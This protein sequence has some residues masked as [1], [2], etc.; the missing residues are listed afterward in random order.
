MLRDRMRTFNKYVTNR[1]LRVFASLSHGPF[2]IVRHVGRRS[3]KPYETVIMVWPMGEGFV[4][5]LTYGPEV[6]W[7]RNMLAAEGGAVFWHSKVYAVGKPEPIDV[8]TALTAFPA[9]FRLVLGRVGLRNFVRVK[10][11]EPSPA[12]LEKAARSE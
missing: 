4:I 12:T 3:G 1:I 8:Q 9:A 2:A 11:I 7:Y 6:D 5:A 10:F